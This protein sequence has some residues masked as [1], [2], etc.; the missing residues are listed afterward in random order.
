M[1]LL[2]SVSVNILLPPAVCIPAYPACFAA[3]RDVQVW[4]LDYRHGRLLY[5]FIPSRHR[6]A[7]TF[8]IGA[9]DKTKRERGRKEINQN[10]AVHVPSQLPCWRPCRD[11][12]LAG[13]GRRRVSPGFCDRY[14]G[15]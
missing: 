1:S 13:T 12:L 10:G 14:L 15:R 11:R 2:C 9:G 6:L 4:T 3:S 5:R 8:R 7:S